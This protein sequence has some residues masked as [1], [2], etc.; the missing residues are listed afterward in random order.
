MEGMP[1]FNRMQRIC[2]LH[3][4]AL[5]VTD[6][7]GRTLRFCQQ[8]SSCCH[9]GGAVLAALAPA[10]PPKGCRR[11]TRLRPPSAPL[12]PTCSAPACTLS[13]SLKG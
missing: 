6:A 12:L 1:A 9:A 10:P 7:S 8:A 5:A 3:A 4:R 13:A 11:C 2:P